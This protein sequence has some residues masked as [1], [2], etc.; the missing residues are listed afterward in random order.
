MIHGHTLLFEHLLSMGRNG[1]LSQIQVIILKLILG[2]RKT[3]VSLNPANLLLVSTLGA[4]DGT[5]WIFL[6]MGVIQVASVSSVI[7]GISAWRPTTAHAGT[8]W[9]P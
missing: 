7:P 4:V 3:H 6:Q 9:L 2:N 1:G 8:S 5:S